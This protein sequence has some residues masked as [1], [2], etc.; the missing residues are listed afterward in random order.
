MIDSFLGGYLK[1]P[2]R[3]GTTRFALLQSCCYLNRCFQCGHGTARLGDRHAEVRRFA[4]NETGDLFFILAADEH[5]DQVV[6]VDDD[7]LEVVV[8]V[9]LQAA[10]F[11]KML[12]I[13]VTLL[14][15][16]GRLW[17]QPAVRPR[18]SA[19]NLQI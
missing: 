19:E 12:S 4:A 5:V 9:V 6:T 10:R 16:T 7:L 13:I 14:P 18:Q 1:R 15:G 8:A 17:R 2:C 3:N 11:L